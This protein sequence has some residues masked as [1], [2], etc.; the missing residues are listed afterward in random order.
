M[1]PTLRG[2]RAAFPLLLLACAGSG[3]GAAAGAPGESCRVV[4]QGLELPQEVR[5][6]SG[7]AASRRTPGVFWT[8]ND[9]GG[10]PEVFAV[11]S[12]GRLLG[13]VRVAGAENKD[14]EDVAVGPCPGGGSCLYLA[15]TGD[16]D[17][18]RKDVE[19]YRVPEPAPAD[20]A[21]AP[22]EQ[23]RLRYPAGA[24]DAEAVF[25]MPG[26]DLYLVTKGRKHPVEVYRAPAPLRAGAS[27]PLVRLGSL[28]GR[29]ERLN[30]VTGASATPDGR[31]VAVRTYAA[32]H[33]FR[34]ADLLA[35]GEPES[36]RVDLIP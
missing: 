23:I 16:N 14:W 8:H 26:G 3:D 22:A 12:T 2:L 29:A 9:S 31:W 24:R 35:G 36:D 19:V 28:G 13:R 33:L 10:E 4:R 27:V 21:T 32:L 7:L 17:A 11:D 34:A 30:M 20:A 1:H 18:K 15:D 5:E 25:V 6:S